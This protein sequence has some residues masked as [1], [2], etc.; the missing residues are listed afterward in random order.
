MARHINSQ[1]DI[2]EIWDELD[3]SDPEDILSESDDEFI[4]QGIHPNQKT[5]LK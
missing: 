4:P 1:E 5:I 3:I 2:A